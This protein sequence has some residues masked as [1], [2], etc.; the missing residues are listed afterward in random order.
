MGVRVGKPWSI[1]CSAWTVYPFQS[2]RLPIC[3]NFLGL[4]Q[5]SLY[6]SLHKMCQNAISKGR[7]YF[8]GK[9]AAPYPYVC[10]T[11]LGAK[12]IWLCQGKCLDDLPR[13][14]RNVLLVGDHTFDKALVRWAFQSF[15]Q[16]VRWALVGNCSTK[17]GACLHWR[18]VWFH[19]SITIIKRQFTHAALPIPYQY[20][21]LTEEWTSPQTPVHIVYPT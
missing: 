17:V 20:S 10:H 8:S 5:G 3:C 1:L 11:P 21:S 12:T 16:L 15:P 6:T 9:T 7:F 2:G 14:S 4:H 13:C 19:N 18:G